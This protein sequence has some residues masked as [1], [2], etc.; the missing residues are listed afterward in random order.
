MREV[1]G[2]SIVT[3]L[4]FAHEKKASLWIIVIVDAILTVSKFVHSEKA[5]VC[6]EVTP[7][8][9]M[10]FFIREKLQG[11]LVISPVP[12]I[13]NKPSELSVYVT[14]SPHDPW[15]SYGMSL[16]FNFKNR[17]ESIRKKNWKYN[18]K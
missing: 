15:V 2:V 18:I 3:V 9:M 12:E 1:F 4:S 7:L 8:L 16:L 17:N 10:T 6:I 5:L 14:L 13:V 11:E